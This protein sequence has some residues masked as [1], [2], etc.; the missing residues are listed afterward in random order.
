MIR[1][2]PEGN[3]QLLLRSKHNGDED[4]FDHFEYEL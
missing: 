2:N 1:G 4:L 3:M